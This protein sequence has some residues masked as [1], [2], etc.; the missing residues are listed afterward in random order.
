MTSPG[1]AT[2]PDP[3]SARLHDSARPRIFSTDGLTRATTS[4]PASTGS[5]G[6]TSCSGVVPNGPRMSGNPVVPRT[7]VNAAGIRC[8]C[9][10]ATSSI[11]ASTVEPRTALPGPGPS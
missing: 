2:K 5:G 9:S 11:F 3:S 1:A 6:G 4:E 7:W 8:S 10:G